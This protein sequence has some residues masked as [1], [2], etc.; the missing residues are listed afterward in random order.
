MAGSQLKRLKASLKDQG[1]IGPQKSKKQKRQNA[2]DARASNE[3]RI[4]RHEALASIREQFNPFQFKTNARG[5]KFEVTT[6]KPV[7]SR[8]AMGI[9][10]RPGLTKAMGEQRRRETLLV[11]MQRRNKVGGLIDRRFG[12]DDPNMSLEDKMIE[13]Y[14][15]EQQRSHKKHSAFD[16]EDDELMG[17]LTHMG[18]PLFDDDD[19]PKFLKD[20]FEEDVGSG[21]E[22]DGSQ[23]ERRALKRQRL[24]E[25]LEAV[26]EQEQE[27][28]Q[29][30]RKKTKK[31]IYDEII[32]KSKLHKELRQEAKEEDNELRAEIDEAMRDLRPL[33]FDRIKPSTKDDKP[34]LVIAGKDQ[35]A[36]DREYDIQ[37]KRMAADKRAAPTDK[38]K[39]EEEQ[40]VEEANRLKKLEEDRLKRMRGE[41]VSDDEQESDDEGKQGGDDDFDAMDIEDV[42]E[43]GLGQGIGGKAT[44]YRPTATELGFDDEDDFL[45]D[46]DLVASGSE[47]EFDSDDEGEES[48]EDDESGSG[49]EEDSDDDEFTKGL[50]TE[51]EAKEGIFRLPTNTNGSDENG[52]PYTFP[53][54]QTH[55]EILEIFKGI[56]VTQLPVAT[57]RIRALYHPKL[58]S[59]N[60]ERLGNFVQALVRHVNYLGNQY[61]P[62]WAASLEGLTRHIHSL[63]KSFPI[64]V[65]KGYRSIIQEME[66]SRPLALTVGDLL[67]L[68]GVGT[69]F[70][71]SDHFHQVV[72][73]AMI[74]I[75]RYLGQKIPQNLSDYATG[76]FLSILA[77]QYQQFSKRYVP[78]VMNFSLNILC[79]LSPSPKAFTPNTIGFFPIHDPPAGTRLPKTLPADTPPARKLNFSDCSTT[80]AP[81]LQLK[82]SLLE[83]TISLLSTASTLWSQL[84]S[85]TE[86]FSPA[87]PLLHSLPK[88]LSPSIQ[89]LNQHLT[90]LLQISKLARRP[91]ELH[92]HR[93]LAI[94]T[95]VPKFEDSFDPNKHYDPDRERAEMAKLKA[96]H[97]RE[98]KGALRELRKDN[99][100]MARENLRVKK[101]KDAAYEKKY[102]RLVAEIQGTEGQ[103]A[104]AYEREKAARRKKR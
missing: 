93:P 30:E 7:S 76:S 6:N 12:E 91:L 100:F 23:T 1:I 65:A 20:D 75:A 92:H 39:T 2:Q 58:A 15:R 59:E 86:T 35:A 101:E 9:S 22:S 98:R 11:E 72:T 96:E 44:K 81:S 71:T 48:G 17:G 8:E 38:T 32:A 89:S 42:D 56:D 103:A 51:A 40:A 79:A 57:Q 16:L 31:E 90:R 4:Q 43:F 36:L 45:I 77:L 102:K 88:S 19:A 50:L 63:A 41:K 104:N 13:R 70:P 5:P 34:S 47:L 60:K 49:S 21:D 82:L 64:E 18:K 33:L 69:T 99:A 97:K 62:T 95:Y 87:P 25:A 61:Q 85:F 80:N 26:G 54:P 27:D 37:V 94:R 68:A 78:E 46:D 73:P 28:G 10:G 84:P 29:P 66:Q 24:E 67:T 14:T 53:C 74:V 52:V 55:D 83:T 3:K